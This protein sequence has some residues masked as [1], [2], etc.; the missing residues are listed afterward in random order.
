M[1]IEIVAPMVMNYSGMHYGYSCSTLVQPG[2]YDIVKMGNQW[3]AQ[4]PGNV[5][6][7]YD[8]NLSGTS[9][10]Y[11]PHVNNRV[12]QAEIAVLSLYNDYHKLDQ[13]PDGA[14]IRQYNGDLIL[15][16]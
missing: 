15:H 13:L 16:R 8:G 12:G 9:G 7:N 6:S 3:V 1:Q 4:L 2:R 14:V 10:H 5:V 11:L